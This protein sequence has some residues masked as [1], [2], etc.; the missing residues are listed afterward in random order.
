MKGAKIFLFLIIGVLG[1]SG[2]LWFFLR[3]TPS[4]GVR[5]VYKTTTVLNPSGETDSQTHAQ[6]RPHTHGED[7][8][9]THAHE[10][11]SDS[12]IQIFSEN[13]GDT[14]DPKLL[15]WLAYL[16]SEEGRA[17]FDNFPS[18]DEWFEK[19]KS[20][21]FF[22]ETPERQASTDQWYRQHFPT[23]TVDENA[24][25]IRDMMRDAILEHEHHKED[26]P[27][28]SR[29]A[30]VLLQMLEDDKFLA[31]FEKKF[32]LEPPSSQ[33]WIFETFEEIRLAEREKYLASEKN[34]TTTRINDSTGSERPETEI[35]LPLGE[36]Q[37]PANPR[38]LS[39]DTLTIEDM[40]SDDANTQQTGIETLTPTVPVSPELPTHKSLETALRT[41]FSPDRFNRAMKT[42]NQYGP[43]EGL[44]RLKSSDP[45]VAKQVERLLPKPQGED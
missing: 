12:M 20:F 6:G 10:R 4:P 32:G 28:R 40:F 44:R 41:Q 38:S 29:N 11:P 17:F 8:P 1:F 34:D 39:E 45:E 33:K 9:H 19:S 31:W 37:T 3:Q 23:G 13:I 24:S 2:I 36:G 15:R 35:E 25:I 14:T 27:S 22:Q 7:T 26:E 43:Q 5:K 21:G 18:P 42:L 30:D 16:E